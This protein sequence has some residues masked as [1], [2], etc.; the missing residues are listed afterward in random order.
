MRGDWIT[1]GRKPLEADGVFQVRK[2]AVQTRVVSEGKRRSRQAIWGLGAQSE[3]WR[4]YI[5]DH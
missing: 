1:A 5:D 3:P 2:M 4:L